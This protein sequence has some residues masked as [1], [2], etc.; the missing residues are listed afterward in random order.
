MLP[1]PSAPAS[2][3]AVGVCKSTA[4]VVW[5]AWVAPAAST[6]SFD[7]GI[8]GNTPDVKDAE[9]CA[10]ATNFENT[11]DLYGNVEL[12]G[13]SAIVKGGDMGR[14]DGRRT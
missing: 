1:S 11:N 3:T 10:C 5:A 2:S 8:G 12:V 7:S 4:S 14:F 6:P 13:V 9:K